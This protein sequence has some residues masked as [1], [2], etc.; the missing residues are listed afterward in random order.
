MSDQYDDC[1]DQGGTFIVSL[2]SIEG[3]DNANEIIGLEI[4]GYMNSS[5]DRPNYSN[6]PGMRINLGGGWYKLKF[7]DNGI[8]RKA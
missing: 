6:T 8:L 1:R 7:D 2:P 4:T 5:A 3:G